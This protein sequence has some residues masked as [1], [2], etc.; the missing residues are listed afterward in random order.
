MTFALLACSGPAEAAPR[1]VPLARVAARYGFPAPSVQGTNVTLRSSTAT[2]NFQVDSRRLVSNGVLVWLNAPLLR[3]G[4]RLRLCGTDVDVVLDPLL[5]ANGPVNAPVVRTIVLDPGHGGRD[6]GAGDRAGLLEKHVAL[7]IARRVR[8][9]FRN[10]GITVKLTREGD[11]DIPLAARTHMAGKWDADLFLS[12]HLNSAPNRN[13]AGVETHV[14]ASPGFEATSTGTLPAKAY[15]GNRHDAL[16][17]RLAYCVQ[18]GILAV[19]GAP[20]RGIRR[21]RFQVLREAPCPAALLE[22]GFLSN[23]AEAAQVR[24]GAYVDKLAEGLARGILTC[25]SGMGTGA[26]TT[27]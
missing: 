20:D 1:Q 22:C 24:R 13:A 25:V 8:R 23:S 16:S 15:R 7:D 5:R 27:P 10:S 6:P 2:L 11:A 26:T 18:R 17:M 12:V 3:D 21:S 19:T 14:L 9:R 4:R